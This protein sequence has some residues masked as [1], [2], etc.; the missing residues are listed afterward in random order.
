[1]RF[2]RQIATMCVL[3]LALCATNLS[4]AQAA[5]ETSPAGQS[6]QSPENNAP[7]A[8]PTATQEAAPAANKGKKQKNKKAKGIRAKK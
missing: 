1:M 6:A 7:P 5:A 4:L 3:G 8:N 2:C